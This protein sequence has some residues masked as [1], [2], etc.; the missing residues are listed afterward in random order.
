M[1]ACLIIISFLLTSLICCL[2]QIA[3]IEGDRLQQRLCEEASKAS[4]QEAAVVRLDQALQKS[5]KVCYLSR[6]VLSD[7][8]THCWSNGSVAVRD[9]VCLPSR[10]T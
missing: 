9:L 7:V 4:R 10:R 3:Q 8:A 2:V 1:C 6:H 5:N